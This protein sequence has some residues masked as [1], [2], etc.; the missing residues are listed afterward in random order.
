MIF[1]FQSCDIKS[2][3]SYIIC[4]YL[5]RLVIQNSLKCTE[6]LQIFFDPLP[7][8]IGIFFYKLRSIYRTVADRPVSTLIPLQLEH[9]LWTI[10]VLFHCCT[11]IWGLTNNNYNL[12]LL[13]FL[14]LSVSIYVHAIFAFPSYLYIVEPLSKLAYTYFFCWRLHKYDCILCGINSKHNDILKKRGYILKIITKSYVTRNDDTTSFCF[15]NLITILVVMM[16][17]RRRWTMM[18]WNILRMLLTI[19]F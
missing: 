2:E 3:Y 5:R 4:W 7:N 15:K 10:V 8:P 12:Y 13:Q 9:R 6:T 16:M 17:M 1:V 11:L 19:W 14:W 18:I